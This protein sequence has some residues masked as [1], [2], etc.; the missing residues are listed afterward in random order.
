MTSSISRLTVSTILLIAGLVVSLIEPCQSALAGDAP[1]LTI[2]LTSD[3][4]SYSVGESIVFTATFKN[5]GSVPVT[6]VDTG[7]VGVLRVSTLKRDGKKVS[8]PPVSALFANLPLFIAID[9]QSNHYTLS[10]GVTHVS[11][12]PTRTE[13]GVLYIPSATT[14][15]KVKRDG[16]RSVREVMQLYDIS[17]PGTYSLTLLYKTRVPADGEP[18]KSR[19]KILT[20]KSSELT[21]VVE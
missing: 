6:I 20:I 18:V 13:R 16:T 11:T 19:H 12:F 10:P 7:G 2:T 17:S 14:S 15:T 8:R 1:K 5:T 3:K 9:A 21:F 4:A